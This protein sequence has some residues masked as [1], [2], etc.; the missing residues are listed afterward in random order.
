M[1][2]FFLSLLPLGTLSWT[3]CTDF[4]CSLLAHQCFSTVGIVLSEHLSFFSL[5]LVFPSTRYCLCFC[6][7]VWWILLFAYFSACCL[8][9]FFSW[10]VSDWWRQL[11]ASCF[12][13]YPHPVPRCLTLVIQAGVGISTPNSITWQHLSTSCSW[14]YPIPVPRGVSLVLCATVVDDLACI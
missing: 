5:S 6:H 3:W 13:W 11:P 4:S 10:G 8:Y 2:L 12:W 7:C 14:W 9:D 1:T